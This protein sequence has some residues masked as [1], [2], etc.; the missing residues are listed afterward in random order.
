MLE[1]IP[2]QYIKIVHSI[3]NYVTLLIK[4]LG[5]FLGEWNGE[6]E[7]RKLNKTTQLE[8]FTAG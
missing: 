3:H 2:Y 5:T 4:K 8:Q 6:T 1:S 7:P